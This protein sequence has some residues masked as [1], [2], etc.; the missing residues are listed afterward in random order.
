LE[1]KKINIAL[2]ILALSS[3]IFSCN[4]NTKTDDKI[5][6]R[7][8]DNVLYLQEI[9]DIIPNNIN[10][11][12]SIYIAQ[13]YI[14]DWIKTQLYLVN[15]KKNLSDEQMDFEKE[16]LAYKNSLIIHTYQQEILKEKCKNI[17]L[18]R[19]DLLAYYHSH[20]EE[21]TSNESYYQLRYFIGPKSSLQKEELRSL[22]KK[23]E[24]TNDYETY[25]LR[26]AIDYFADNT[27]WISIQEITQ[28]FPNEMQNE[29]RNIHKTKM[30][31]YSDSINYYA[32]MIFNIQ[33]ENEI[34]DFEIVKDEIEETI[35]FEKKIQFI[36]DFEQEMFSEAEKKANIEIFTQ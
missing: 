17:H 5:I 30:I 34:K 35:I 25:C 16:M 14:N 1:K 19:E 24:N 10:K 18:S 28:V 11:E 3:F 15:A 8:Y 20:K 21:F 33:E 23:E 29:I 27:K 32:I 13:S 7:A 12:D 6:A 9:K 2:I 26:H 4:K 31:E 22:I 36:K